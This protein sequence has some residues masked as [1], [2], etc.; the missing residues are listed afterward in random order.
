MGLCQ[1][2]FISIK[3][4][5]HLAFVYNGTSTTIYVNGTVPATVTGGVVS[6]SLINT[7]SFYNFFGKDQ[8]GRFC[9]AQLDEICLYN[10]GLTYPTRH[11][12]MLNFVSIVLIKIFIFSFSNQS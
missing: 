8:Y 7:T 12:H 5:Y 4:W 2:N 10:K 1:E 6:S 3:L 11:R 9:D